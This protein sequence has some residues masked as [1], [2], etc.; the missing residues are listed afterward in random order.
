MYS[1]IAIPTCNH[2]G[3]FFKYALAMKHV[4]PVFKRVNPGGMQAL[5]G[6]KCL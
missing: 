6:K 4:G 1:G 5:G 3:V 2:E